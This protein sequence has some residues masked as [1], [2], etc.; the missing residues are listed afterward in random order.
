V[1][2]DVLNQLGIE[3]IL[4]Q[5]FGAAALVD[6]LPE[7]IGPI[8]IKPIAQ[9]KQKI[10]PIKPILEMVRQNPDPGAYIKAIPEENILHFINQVITRLEWIKHGNEGTTDTNQD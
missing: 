10:E 5:I 1:A 7:S 6:M 8:Q 2:R 9:I 3:Q 4:N